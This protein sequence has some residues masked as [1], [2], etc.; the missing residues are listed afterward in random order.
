[1]SLDSKIR[2]ILQQSLSTVDEHQTP[3]ARLQEDAERLF[4]LCRKFLSMNLIS[5]ETADI[6][7][8][9]TACFALQ[10][11]QR[12]SKPPTAG[13]LGRSNLKDRAE[14]SAELMVTLFD[15]KIEDML[16]DR[17][18][19][20]LH[21][22]PHK[23][24]VPEEARLLADAINLDEF[25]LVG[26]I[27][28]MIQLARQGDGVNQ[29]AEGCEKRDQYGYWDARLKE[30]FHFEPIRQLARR[31]VNNARQAARMLLDELNEDQP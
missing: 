27:N 13:R 14:Q 26:L 29:L 24:P 28:Q 19:R 18:A 12:Q 9:E 23:S 8:L 3:G 1:M 2:R 5:A 7:A 15:G 30:G 20:L 11:P 16:L 31:R 25:G 21:E 17:A 6:E 22:M 4:N 10:L